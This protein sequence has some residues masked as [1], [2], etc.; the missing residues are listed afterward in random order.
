MVVI[1]VSISL[2]YIHELWRKA[3]QRADGAHPVLHKGHSRKV[4]VHG[5]VAIF[6]YQPTQWAFV[7]SSVKLWMN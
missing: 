3:L 1:K 6:A 2:Y 4:I 7:A 5:F